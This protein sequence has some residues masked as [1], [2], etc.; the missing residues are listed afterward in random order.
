MKPH[1]TDVMRRLSAADPARGQVLDEAERARVWQLITAMP[2]GSSTP[3][4]RRTRMRRLAL[5]VPALLVLTAGA[6][7]A[8]GVIRIGAPAEPVK[9][10]A[11]VLRG[12]VSSRGPCDCCR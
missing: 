12:G 5:V 8:G 4:R 9:G 3:A 7:A 11:G 2:G 1:P 6:L 10:F